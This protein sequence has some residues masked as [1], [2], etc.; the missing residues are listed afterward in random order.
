MENED[1]RNMLR[2]LC[3]EEYIDVM[4]VSSEMPDVTMK[5]KTEGK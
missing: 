3:E 2:T 5:V 4:I 1:R